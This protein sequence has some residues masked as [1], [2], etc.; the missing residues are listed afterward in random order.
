MV[1]RSARGSRGLLYP[2]FAASEIAH[3]VLREEYHPTDEV[4]NSV[5]VYRKECD[6]G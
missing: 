2:A 1:I 5:F 3:V 4:I 6:E